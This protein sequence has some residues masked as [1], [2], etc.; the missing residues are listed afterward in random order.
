MAVLSFGCELLLNAAATSRHS[1]AA[2]VNAP[3]TASYQGRASHEPI[4]YVKAA[5]RGVARTSS[6][7]AA[8]EF[9][10]QVRDT[11]GRLGQLRGITHRLPRVHGCH[12]V[13][14]MILTFTAQPDVN[15]APPAALSPAL[16]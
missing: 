12:E 4:A 11:H 1:P 2:T 6:T 15:V 10:A 16:P 3:D 8:G 14:E 9:G 7:A 5:T 13:V